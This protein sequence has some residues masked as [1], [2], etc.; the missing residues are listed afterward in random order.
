MARAW[1]DAAGLTASPSMA[2][3]ARNSTA[4][5]TS[6]DMLCPASGLSATVV[7]S[8]SRTLRRDGEVGTR[9]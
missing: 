3:T 4:R 5:S 9:M 1:L 2:S 8:A 7:E 6:E